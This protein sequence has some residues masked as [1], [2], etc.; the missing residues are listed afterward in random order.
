LE[1]KI[2]NTEVTPQAIWHIAKALLKRYRPREPTAIRGSSC[3]KFHPSEKANAIA[4]CLEIVF[5]P[6][7]LCDENHERLVE[8][9]VEILLEAVDNSPLRGYDHVT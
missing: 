6:H 4:E 8:A 1:T 5:T 7:D 3:L 2:G 9:R